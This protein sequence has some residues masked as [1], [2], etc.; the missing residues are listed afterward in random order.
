MPLRRLS[1]SR[2]R[3]RSRRDDAPRVLGSQAAVQ[4]QV[5]EHK[6]T[7]GCRGDGSLYDQ[8]CPCGSKILA[9]CSQCENPVLMLVDKKRPCRHEM[10]Y[11]RAD[12]TMLRPFEGY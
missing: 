7:Y 5:D 2:H 10:I 3:A 8:A 1:R 12:G 4:A 11:T 9:M 6:A